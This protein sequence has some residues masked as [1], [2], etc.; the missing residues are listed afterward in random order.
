MASRPRHSST[1]PS[2]WL[3]ACAIVVALVAVPLIAVAQQGT[4]EGAPTE[5]WQE[6]PTPPPP[7]PTPIPPTPTPL[8]PTPTP[9]PPT[10]TLVPPTPTPLP[11]TPTPNPTVIPNSDSIAALTPAGAVTL[12]PG[13]A[14][15]LAFAYTVTTERT[16]TSIHAELRDVNGNGAGGWTL[17]SQAGQGS[18]AGAGTVADLDETGTLAPGGTF[19]LTV[20][21]VAPAGITEAQ[22][23][24]LFVGTTVS[25]ASGV[26]TGL[27]G[28][29]PLVAATV[30]PPPIPTPTETPIVEPTETIAAEP[31]EILPAEASPAA[32]A[33]STPAPSP[34]PGS[35]PVGTPVAEVSPA[36]G[37]PTPGDDGEAPVCDTRATV[38]LAGG[39]VDFG[40]A[41]AG[42]PRAGTIRIAVGQPSCLAAPRIVT[43]ALSSADGAGIDGTNPLDALVV[44]AIRVDG[45][46]AAWLAPG[47]TGPL[48]PGLTVATVTAAGTASGVVEVDV[49]LDVPADAPSGTYSAALTVTIAGE[50][51][52]P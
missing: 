15:E 28:L 35:E 3:V 6:V 26:E 17:Q 11:P 24:N 4:P 25:T 8:P 21:I 41:G 47:S 51:P 22:T 37:T 12:Q 9:L 34:T 10:P 30:L 40:D 2:A 48:G 49:W 43:L 50:D 45:E 5:T 1:V 18:W 32:D 20:R 16:A 23:V 44:T 38:D 46:D 36:A 7:T 31:A 33:T 27:P 52:P 29:A 39:S 14:R 19:T 13:E 42:E